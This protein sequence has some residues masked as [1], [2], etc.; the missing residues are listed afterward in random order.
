MLVTSAQ[1]NEFNGQ[2]TGCVTATI[3]GVEMSVPKD[4]ANRHYA[5]ILAWA[6]EDGNEIQA[7]E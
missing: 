3:D 5:A 4:P 6:E 7:A 2:D 1:H